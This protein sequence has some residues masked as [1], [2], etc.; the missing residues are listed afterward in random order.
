VPLIAAVAALLLTVLAAAAL[1][2]LSLVLRYRAGTA[3]R[4]ARGW[5]AALNALAMAASATLFACAAAVTS[6]WVPRA[7]RYTL[8]GFAAGA[9]LGL[10]GLWWSR[11]ETTPHA[12]HYTPNRWLV[13]GLLVLVAARIGYGFWRTWHAWHT[14]GPDTSW[15]AAAGVAGSLGAGAVVLGYYL[16]YWTGVWLRIKRHRRQR[17]TADGR[18]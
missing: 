5:V 8:I 16:A 7:L 11:W 18:S 1:M 10:L 14:T 9:V 15:L 2:P 12:L 13:L 6:L 4:Q 3:R 17:A